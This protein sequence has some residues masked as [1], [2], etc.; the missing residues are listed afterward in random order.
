MK[1]STKGGFIMNNY[2]SNVAVVL[3]FLKANSYGT[4]AVCTHK[5][6]YKQLKEFLITNSLEFSEVNCQQWYSEY[7]K[8]LPEESTSYKGIG[9]SIIHL[10]DVYECGYIKPVHIVPSKPPYQKLPVTLRQEL[11]EYIEFL[12]T[13]EH[14]ESY[15]SVLRSATSRFMLF[16]SDNG[17]SSIKECTYDIIFAFFLRDDQ[18]LNN[19]KN[20]C[21]CYAKNIL[22]YYSSKYEKLLGM[23]LALDML[24]INH[25]VRD[26]SFLDVQ[27]YE[28][29]SKN[30]I[31]FSWNDICLF[32]SDLKQ[33]GYKKTNINASNHILKLLYIFKEMYSKPLIEAIIWLW[34]EETSKLIGLCFKQH[35]RS[36][37]QFLIYLKSNT[38][39]TAVTGLPNKKIAFDCICNSLRQ[40]AKEFL[41]LLKR[42]G[43]AK[44]TIDM[45]RSS[46]TRFCSFIQGEEITE[47]NK[48]TANIIV[49]FIKQDKHSTFEGKQAYNCKIRRFLMYLSDEGIIDN[50]T[51]YL[52]VPSI[53]APKVE[54][55][56][57]LTDDDIKVILQSINDTTTP[58][59]LRTNAIVMLGLFTGLRASDVVSIKFSQI[60]WKSRT[61]NIVQQK[62]GKLITVYF[63]VKVGNALFKYIKYARPKR[64]SPYVFL[65]HRMPY[66]NPSPSICNKALR[67]ILPDSKNFN[68]TFHSVRKTF[69][70][71]LLNQNNKVEIISDALGH[72]S[73]SNVYTYLSLDSV[74]MRMCAL[75]LE[76]IG[77]CYKAGDFFG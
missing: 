72:R 18:P 2:D 63:P 26:F 47:Y 75:P 11:D 76:S 58:T 32:I 65:I 1:P 21:D 3:D 38:I 14:P 43:R 73:D 6:C 10:Q 54:I 48:I 74:R 28:Y 70:T 46:I 16:L 50:N 42:E 19:H 59:Q 71:G 68:Q 4:T 33:I 20:R 44:S 29:A 34:F 37:Y 67:S 55:P 8:T 27:E 35:R 7:C 36:L 31:S 15:I 60:D 5:R 56:V 53:A 12:S 45:Y 49:D 24:I 17:F 25:I 30:D 39:T 41:T 77:I 13:Y 57:I 40:P 9:I 61:I 22:A 69:A 62:T 64:E 51:L 66:N 52:A 23:S